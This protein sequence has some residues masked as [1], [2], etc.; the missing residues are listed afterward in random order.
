MANRFLEVEYDPVE[1]KLYASRK[2]E[3]IA[4]VL[5]TPS[6]KSI[7]T[8]TYTITAD[9]AES[10]LICETVDTTITL[11]S[12]SFRLGS[13]I[14]LLSG[15]SNELT[16]VGSGITLNTASSNTS[17]SNTYRNP[18]S[19]AKITLTCVG[20]DKWIVS[21]DITAD[22]K[23]TYTVTADSGNYVFNGSGLSDSI[24]PALTLSVGQFMEI[25]NQSGS[26]HPFVVKKG[27]VSGAATGAGPT[28][29]GWARLENNNQ[30]GSDNK[31]RVSFRE[32]GDYY[33]ICQVHSTMKG[34]I[35]VS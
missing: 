13:T 20:T 14:T 12:G 28:S 4:R 17:S 2:I 30:H 10:V 32:T 33:Y 16:L 21:G 18:F 11:S 29:P 19:H 27:N 23:K 15:E 35:T 26:S 3:G 24:N 9:D 31:L 7:T 34:A 8:S 1:D 25:D 22:V 6:S 5:L